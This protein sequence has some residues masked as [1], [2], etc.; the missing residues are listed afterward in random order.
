MEGLE[1][2]LSV[3]LV[4]LIVFCMYLFCMMV[5]RAFRAMGGVWKEDDVPTDYT[6]EWWKRCPD[7]GTDERGWSNECRCGYKWEVKT[8]KG[9]VK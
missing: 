4:T 5:D 1:L 8:K 7:C 6:L 3:L 9:V 2:V